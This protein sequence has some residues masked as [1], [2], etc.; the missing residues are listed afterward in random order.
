[1]KNQF[2][3]FIGT[4]VTSS[5]GATLTLNL[6]RFATQYTKAQAWLDSE[7]LKDSDPYVPMKTGT[8]VKSG[9]RGTTLGSGMIVYNAPY[10][11]RMYYGIGYNFNR[12]KHP[13]AQAF[14]FEAAKSSNKTKWIR[15]VRSLGGGG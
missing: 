2:P 3:E 14:W 6:G 11:R 1:M 7:V 15:G 4:H 10:A 12:T 5:N 13:N 9:I 8:L